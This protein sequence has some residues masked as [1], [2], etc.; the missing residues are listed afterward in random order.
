VDSLTGER[1]LLGVFALAT[2]VNVVAGAMF[3][4]RV[5]RAAWA[6]PLGVAAVL[7]GVPALLLAVAGAASG[8]SW[9]RWVFPLLYAVFAAVTLLLDF[10]LKVE[11]RSPRRSRILAPFLILYYVPL[12]AMWGMLWDLGLVYWALNGVSYLGMLWASL[13]A[14][15]KGAG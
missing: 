12:V 15:R 11:F 3:W 5:R 13:W 9:T 4:A 8:V 6:G 7:L 1:F 10:I 14:V 2:S